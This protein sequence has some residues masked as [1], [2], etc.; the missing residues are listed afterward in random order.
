MTASL[1]R[2]IGI[3]D[4]SLTPFWLGDQLVRSNDI[5]EPRFRTPRGSGFYRIQKS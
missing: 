3:L 2:V 5:K 4:L 1:Q